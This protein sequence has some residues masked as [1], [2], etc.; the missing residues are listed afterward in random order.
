MIY[1]NKN[2]ELI[3]IV[4]IKDSIYIHII[5]FIIKFDVITN[6][7]TKFIN[8]LPVCNYN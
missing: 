3:P 1:K 6:K 7:L 4:Y 2:G 8:P 5:I